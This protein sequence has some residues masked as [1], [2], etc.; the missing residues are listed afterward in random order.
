MR[1]TVAAI[2]LASLL[3]GQAAPAPT[4][5]GVQKIYIEKTPNDLDQYIQAEIAKKLKGRL[6]VVLK[7][8]DADAIMTGVGEHKTGTGAA[9]TGRMLGLHD[10]ATAAVSIVDKSRQTIL[11]T[12]EAGD[13]S[14]LF[15]VFT[16]GG[17]RKV[18][19][20]LVKSLNKALEQ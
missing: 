15:G 20:R 4:L 9:V 17:P 8:E 5:K 14:L 13:R 3:F 18:A 19:S 1:F 7:A 6:T 16:R 11:W 10:T 12:S 2:A